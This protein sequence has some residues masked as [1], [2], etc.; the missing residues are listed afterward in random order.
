MSL[1]AVGDC[2]EDLVAK[3][4]LRDANLT[5]TSVSSLIDDLNQK[6]ARAGIAPITRA[7][8]DPGAPPQPNS[9]GLL[10]ASY[11]RLSVRAT[12]TAQRETSIAGLEL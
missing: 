4:F 1:A 12:A 6:Y 5:D 3:E 10:P 7:L 2:A 8:C 9:L 11:A